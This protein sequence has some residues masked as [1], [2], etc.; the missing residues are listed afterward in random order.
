VACVIV[1][2]ALVFRVP[3]NDRVELAGLDGV[4]M[5]SMCLSK[6]MFGIDCPGCGLTRSLLCFFQ[7]DFAN[8]LALHRVGWIMAVAVV[9]QFPYRIWALVRKQDYPLGKRFPEVFGFILI[10]LLIGNWLVGF[11]LPH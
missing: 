1:G 9:L 6:S 3:S 4:P 8:S 10:V 5:P 7:G 2:S 11:F